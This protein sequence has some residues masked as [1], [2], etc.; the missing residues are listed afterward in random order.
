MND[1]KYTSDE[2]RDYR[3]EL[4]RLLREVGPQVLDHWRDILANGG[5]Q[6]V[7]VKCRNCGHGTRA[8]VPIA[9]VQQQRLILTFLQEQLVTEKGA[10]LG[11]TKLDQDFREMTN[12]ELNQQ[13]VRLR[14]E[15]AAEEAARTAGRRELRE[16]VEALTNEQV[17]AV[18]ECIKE[19]A[20][21]R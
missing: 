8:T 14:A 13:I 20:D 6:A 4:E 7:N 19:I 10:D 5:K 2:E 16:L 11:A 18:L 12:E 1:N 21:D 15:L 17:P 3:V 9:D